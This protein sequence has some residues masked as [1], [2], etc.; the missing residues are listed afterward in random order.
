MF[1]ELYSDSNLNEKTKN[2]YCSKLLSWFLRLGLLE[3]SCGH[4]S[5]N[6]IA[7]PKAIDVDS[8]NMRKRVRVRYRYN[9][10][11]LFWG[12]SSPEAME[13]AYELIKSGSHSYVAMKNDGYRN[14][15][16]L[17]SA[18][19]ALRRVGDYIDLEKNLTEIYTYI[20]QSETIGFAKMHMDKDSSIRGADMGKLLNEK[21]FRSWTNASMIRYGSSLIRWVRY[22]EMKQIVIPTIIDQG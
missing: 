4:I 9:G 21:F 12:Q 18:A 16:E 14:A 13:T 3:E 20:S 15:I 22:L 1:H 8:S 6:S 19:Q 2:T 17:L 5:V 10:N 7:S 11:N